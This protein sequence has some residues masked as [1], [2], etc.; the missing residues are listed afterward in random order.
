MHSGEAD[1]SVVPHNILTSKLRRHGFD[2]QTVRWIRNWLDGHFQSVVVNGSQSKCKSPSDIPQG[3]VLGPIL[4][5]IYINDIDC[6]IETIISKFAETKLSGAVN[7]L[8]VRDVFQ[9]DLDRLEK[10][11]YA[12]LTKFSNAKCKI[13]HLSQGNPVS[14]NTRMNGLKAALQRGT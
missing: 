12:K 14:I 5:S 4:F 9:R 6:G 3:S 13:L 8:E 11:A 7:S 1:R 2:E 10:W